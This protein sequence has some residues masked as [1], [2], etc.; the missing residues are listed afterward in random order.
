[1]TSSRKGAASR[2][3]AFSSLLGKVE[4]VAEKPQTLALNRIVVRPGQPRRHFD[5]EA[6]QALAASLRVQG[7]LQPILVRPVN[8][9]Y[10]LIAGERRL[11]AARLAG[12]T[13]IP[14]TVREVADQDVSLLAALENLQRQ[15]LNP[16]D[17]VEATITVIARTLQVG[18]SEVIPLLHGQRR[19]PHAETAQQLETLFEQLGRGSW[20]SFAANKAGVLKFPQDLLELLRDG[21]LEYTRASALARIKDE[22]RRRALT[23]RTLDEKLG[24][25]EI[26]TAAKDGAQ[27]LERYRQVRAL[28]DD[29]HLSRLAPKDRS[30]VDEMLVEIERLLQQ[31]TEKEPSS[32]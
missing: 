28:I 22:Q 11:R 25:R 2:A 10:E 18:E 12:L 14:V 1:M 16:L 4:Q 19:K 31:A 20:K 23:Q 8:G 9:Q 15:D 13:E 7:V 17:E 32:S 29:R 21:R 27:P 3:D 6:L 30:W 24:V 26:M 5:E